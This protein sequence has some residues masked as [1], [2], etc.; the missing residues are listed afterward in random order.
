MTND[1]HDFSAS[2]SAAV[3]LSVL[4]LAKPLPGAP[5][6]IAPERANLGDFIGVFGSIL[7][8]CDLG[9]S[10]TLAS[11]VAFRRGVTDLENFFIDEMSSADAATFEEITA[12]RYGGFNHHRIVRQAQMVAE[13]QPT[14]IYLAQ[15][16]EAI[17]Y[18]HPSWLDGTW[19]Q[20]PCHRTMHP[21]MI[22]VEGA[23]SMEE[24]ERCL[25]QTKRLMK[26]FRSALPA[27]VR[28]IRKPRLALPRVEDFFAT[29]DE[30]HAFLR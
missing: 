20:E 11:E 17:L 23:R 24:A 30:S 1:L 12:V 4:A 8:R 15:F 22:M 18:V 28:A 5:H 16:A 3:R 29:G 10:P 6:L 21:L 9:L 13:G 7:H 19:G 14:H 25:E 26:P 27:K 2:S